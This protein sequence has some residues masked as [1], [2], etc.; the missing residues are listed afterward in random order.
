MATKLA[1]FIAFVA[2]AW[3][4]CTLAILAWRKRRLAVGK[5]R[6]T[7]A[8]LR[9]ARPQKNQQSGSAAIFPRRMYASAG[10][11]ASPRSQRETAIADVFSRLPS[12][13][14]VSFRLWRKARIFRDQSGT[15]LADF[16]SMRINPVELF[17][18]LYITPAQEKTNSQ[19]PR[20]PP[21]TSR[22][23]LS[24]ISKPQPMQAVFSQ[25]SDCPSNMPRPQRG[26]FTSVIFRKQISKQT[27]L[28]HEG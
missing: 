3:T 2:P 25:P 28:C 6:I 17:H 15:T 23:R 7:S 16:R 12:S 18:S 19:R 27:G 24:Q 4:T 11:S 1:R 21:S 14:W 8:V 9:P 20:Q 22:L 26:I 10:G 5:T 13:L